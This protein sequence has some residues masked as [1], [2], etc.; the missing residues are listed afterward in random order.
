MSRDQRALRI[1]L[2]IELITRLS[3]LHSRKRGRFDNIDE[4]RAEFQ[5][6]KFGPLSARLFC[7]ACCRCNEYMSRSRSSVIEIRL[8]RGTHT[9]R[10][11]TLQSLSADFSSNYE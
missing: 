4:T 5:F 11:I 7:R 3:R 1:D 6:E 9:R 2:E 10:K 8:H